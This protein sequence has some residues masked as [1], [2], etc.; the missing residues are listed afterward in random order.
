ML[1]LCDKYHHRIKIFEPSKPHFQIRFRYLVNIWLSNGHKL[2][3][4]W[5]SNK[6]IYIY[7]LVI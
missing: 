5:N 1:E 3:S 6:V 4:D 7:V 2:E